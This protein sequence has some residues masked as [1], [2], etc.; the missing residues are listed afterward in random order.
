MTND[1]EVFFKVNVYPHF[2]SQPQPQLNSKVGFC[3]KMTLHHP[4]TTHH[5]NS[6]S[7]IYFNQTLKEGLWDKQQQQAGAELCQAQVKLEVVVEVEF[8]VDVEACHY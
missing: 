2:L 7:S 5:T 8:G 3:M 4:P 6:M 1:N